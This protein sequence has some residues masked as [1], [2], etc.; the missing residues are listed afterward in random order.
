MARPQPADPERPRWGR[1]TLKP[2][3]EGLT[4]RE[5]RGFWESFR[6]PEIARWNGN[7]PLKMPLWLFKRIVMGEVR[8]GERIGFV[9]LDEQGGWLGTLELYD[10]KEREA[11]LGIIL[12]RKDRWGQGYGREAVR[13]VLGYAFGRMGLERVKLR[14]F[15]H[16]ER[17]RRAFRAAGFREV[18]EVELPGGKKDV[19]MEA[20]PEDLEP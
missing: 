3:H 2:F 7:R 19:L 20:R 9:I 10:L 15:A 5:W 6:D 1:V 18:G 14:T 11:T 13:A 4:P 17:A 12:G 16:N 8:R